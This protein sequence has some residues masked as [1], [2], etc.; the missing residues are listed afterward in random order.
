MNKLSFSRFI[1]KTVTD[2]DALSPT[3]LLSEDA[4]LIIGCSWRLRSGDTVLF[5]CCEYKEETTHLDTY[6]KLKDALAG[7]KV[8]RI[9]IDSP[10]SDLVIEFE[11]DLFLQLFNNS[12]LFES[13]TLSDNDKY[14]IVS[15]P[16]GGYS[17]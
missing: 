1:G 11:E 13:W 4:Y 8:K 16:G 3:I 7:K 15:L 12:G 9:S 2:I 10:I 5:G 14:E 6:N 17:V